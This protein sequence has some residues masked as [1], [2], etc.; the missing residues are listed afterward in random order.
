MSQESEQQ[1]TGNNLVSSRDD[2]T[3][4]YQDKHKDH[5]TIRCTSLWIRHNT[6]FCKCSLVCSTETHLH[7]SIPDSQAEKTQVTLCLRNV[8]SLDIELVVVKLSLYYMPREFSYVIPIAVYI[9]PPTNVTYSRIA[10]PS[11]SRSD[12]VMVHL[13]PPLALLKMEPASVRT[14]REWSKN[15]SATLQDCLET[16]TKDIDRF[17][18][19]VT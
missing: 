5:W 7:E 17:A 11:L 19:C 10:F 8:S 1:A 4:Y 12:H 3:L 6:E 18:D 15:A 13:L 9:S 2:T 14:M 16:T